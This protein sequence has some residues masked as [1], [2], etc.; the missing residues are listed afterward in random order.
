MELF[1]SYAVKYFDSF[2]RDHCNTE[3]MFFTMILITAF[4]SCHAFRCKF[5]EI[6]VLITS[7]DHHINI[8]ELSETH[9]RQND[10]A[11]NEMACIHYQSSQTC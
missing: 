10:K 4:S 1:P 3:L 9:D 7:L 6:T 2:P 5:K 11:I 8:S